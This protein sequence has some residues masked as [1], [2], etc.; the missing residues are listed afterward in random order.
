MFKVVVIHLDIVI[1]K[2][3][4]HHLLVSVYQKVVLVLKLVEQVDRLIALCQS[5]DFLAD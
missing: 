3:S 1:L 5:L 4:I 2:H